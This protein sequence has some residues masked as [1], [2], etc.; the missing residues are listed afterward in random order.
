MQVLGALAGP[1][2][3]RG[4]PDARSDHSRPSK[5]TILSL[6]CDF[7]A[8]CLFHLPSPPKAFHSP[9]GT[10]SKT[11]FGGLLKNHV[12][13]P[14]VWFGF[15][16]S[17]ECR[18]LQEMHLSLL[19]QS[20]LKPRTLASTHFSH[21]RAG[22]HLGAEPSLGMGQ[23]CPMAGPHERWRAGLVPLHALPMVY[24]GMAPR[25]AGPDFALQS[26]L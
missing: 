9:E 25:G 2:P 22:R 23:S 10:H 21:R 26:S 19:P 13:N 4:G 5:V 11:T 15:Q 18:K 6:C 14:E 24:T 20:S 17:F 16:G 8:M 1:V 7:Q 3:R 12:L